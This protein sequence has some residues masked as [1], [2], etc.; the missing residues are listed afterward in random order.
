MAEQTESQ[1]K[2]V[3]TVCFRLPDEGV[4][5]VLRRK[6]QAKSCALYL[7]AAEDKLLGEITVWMRSCPRCKRLLIKQHLAHFLTCVCG[8]VWTC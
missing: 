7:K 2:A 8:W 5:D 3:D 4:L 1:V 6:Y